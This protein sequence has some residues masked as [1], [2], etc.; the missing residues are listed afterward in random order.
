MT[1]GAGLCVLKAP[2]STASMNSHAS[3]GAPA[4][5]AIAAVTDAF[6]AGDNAG[7]DAEARLELVRSELKQH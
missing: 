6:A 5:A 3:A 7:D 1:M 2:V 4:K